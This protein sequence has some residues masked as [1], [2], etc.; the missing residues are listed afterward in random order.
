VLASVRVRRTYLPAFGQR[1]IVVKLFSTKQPSK[2]ELY[3]N[4]ICKY[5]K[6]KLLQSRKK[7]NKLISYFYVLQSELNVDDLFAPTDEENSIY[8][9]EEDFNTPLS[10]RVK[11]LDIMSENPIKRKHYRGNKRVKPECSCDV[12]ETER[13]WNNE[14]ATC[15]LG[16]LKNEDFHDKRTKLQTADTLLASEYKVGKNIHIKLCLLK[17]FD[18]DIEARVSIVMIAGQNEISFPALYF[19]NKMVPKVTSLILLA[20]NKVHSHDFTKIGICMSTYADSMCDWICFRK[21]FL[22]YTTEKIYL[23]SITWGEMR[24]LVP[25]IA[26][27]AD[28]YTNML[29]QERTK[30]LSHENETPNKLSRYDLPSTSRTE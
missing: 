8:D 11:P 19:L 1:A 28:Y 10:Q 6:L 22:G 20:S 18:C 26:K 29:L 21:F 9:S 3:Q 25:I 17:V 27:T 13:Q 24:A 4:V 2:F 12:L 30:C 7:I 15:F 14:T 16:Q 23:S 5:L